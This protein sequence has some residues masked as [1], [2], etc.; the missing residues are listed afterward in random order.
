MNRWSRFARTTF[1]RESIGPVKDYCTHV[2]PGTLSSTSVPASSAAPDGELA[3]GELRA[4]PHPAQPEVP[5]LPPRTQHLLVD[6]L[7][8]VAHPHPKL[9]LIVTKLDFDPLGRG[10][11]ERVA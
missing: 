11:A 1:E 4:L 9:P 8:V 2:G 5:F 3:A 10:M 7:A 6:P